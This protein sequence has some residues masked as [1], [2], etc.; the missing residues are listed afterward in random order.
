MDTLPRVRW[1][2]SSLSLEQNLASYPVTPSAPDWFQRTIRSALVVTGD[3]LL[4]PPVLRLRTRYWYSCAGTGP[5][6]S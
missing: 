1:F 3:Q 5:V 4:G 6:C 2:H